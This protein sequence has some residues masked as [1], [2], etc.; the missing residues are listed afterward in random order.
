[1]AICGEDHVCIGTDRTV[2]QIDD[3]TKY[4]EEPRAGVAARKAVG[5]GATSER[6]DIVPVLPDL[7]WPG[8]SHRLAGLPG[9]TSRERKKR[10]ARRRP[11]PVQCVRLLLRQGHLPGTPT[12]RRGVEF[13]RARH[14]RQARHLDLRKADAG[15]LPGVCAIRQNQHAEVR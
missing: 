4:L 14:D 6:A 11:F 7:Q 1:V 2:S 8:K 15:D 5:I 13:P 9:R 3:M 12:V 10:A